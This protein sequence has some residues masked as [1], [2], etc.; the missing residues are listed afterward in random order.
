MRE[1]QQQAAEL[2]MEMQRL[3]DS[4]GL[5]GAEI[6]RIDEETREVARQTKLR[7]EKM[8]LE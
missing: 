4:I 1:A 8:G 7:K 3:R 5:V 6:A 2:D